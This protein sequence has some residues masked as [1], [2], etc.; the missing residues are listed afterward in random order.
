MKKRYLLLFSFLS[1]FLFFG[2]ATSNNFLRQTFGFK[3]PV[4]S[5]KIPENGY[6]RAM[7]YEHFS[8]KRIVGVFKNTEENKKKLIK[9]INNVFSKLKSYNTLKKVKKSFTIDEMYKICNVKV[10][11]GYYGYYRNAYEKQKLINFC[12]DRFP[13]EYYNCWTG[14]KFQVNKKTKTIIYEIPINCTLHR[15]VIKIKLKTVGDKLIIYIEANSNRF[16]AGKL[17]EI[18]NLLIDELHSQG[19]YSIKGIKSVYLFD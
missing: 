18:N 2:C 12:I 17:I 13:A 5:N 11:A 7:K 16:N 14:E 15:Y 3:Y 19:M 8:E 4:Y 9:A 6:Y 10:M 1:V